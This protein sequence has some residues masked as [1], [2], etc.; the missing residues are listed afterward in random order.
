VALADGVGEVAFN[1]LALLRRVEGR[2][3]RAVRHRLHA[4]RSHVAEELASVRLPRAKDFSDSYGETSGDGRSACG[5]HLGAGAH[6]HV[7]L[8]L[9]DHGKCCRV[10]IEALK[11]SLAVVG[12]ADRPAPYSAK[13]KQTEGQ[14]DTQTDTQ[15]HRHTDRYTDTQTDRQTDRQTHRRTDTQTDTQTDRQ[16]NR[17]THRHTHTRARVDRNRGQKHT[18]PA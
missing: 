5:E 12:D 8:N 13:V 9:I 6:P 11:A 3:E 17:Q 16:T 15:T 2:A 10:A 1:Q 18:G 7:I 4:V 14:T